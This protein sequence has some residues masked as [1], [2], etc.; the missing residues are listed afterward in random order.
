MTKKI[1]IDFRW[2][3]LFLS[4]IISFLLRRHPTALTVHVVVVGLSTV[5]YFLLL[6]RYLDKVEGRF[7]HEFMNLVDQERYDLARALIHGQWMLKSLGRKSVLEN[8][9]GLLAITQGDFS[10]ARNHF[11]TA[12]KLV[13]YRDRASVDLNLV[14]TDIA[15][16]DSG[17][18]IERCR[19]ILRER[20]QSPLVQEKLA[21]LLLEEADS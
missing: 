5:A 4:I 10:K 9:S 16:G 13:S 1:E 18:A 21:T 12:R 7:R 20:P 6:P 11:E 19:Q 8:S 15:L 17:I 14:N 2:A 3:A